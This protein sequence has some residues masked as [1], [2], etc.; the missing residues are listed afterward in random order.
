MT[1]TQLEYLIAVAD[2]GSFSKAAEK[3][4][5]TQ[6]A[7]SMQ[8]HKLEE[9]L[10]VIIF[11]RSKKPIKVTPIG[12][13]IIDQARQNLNGME[14]IKEIIREQTDEINGHLRIGIIPTLAPYL[15]PL[16]VTS[17]LNKY[18]LVSLSI[19][20]FISEQ[21]VDKLKQ[22]R[23]DV[24]ILVTPLNDATV[25]EIH[26]F[27]E[28]FVA[29]IST[30]HPLIH[31]EIIDL[32]DLDIDDMLLLNEGHCFREQVIN[33]CPETQRRNWSTRLRFESGSLE[34]LKRIVERGYGYTLL[35]ELAVLNVARENKKFR[36]ELRE[37][38]PV[39]EVSL[40]VH[41]SI[42]KRNLI[43]V[44]KENILDNIPSSLK[45]DNRGTI[46]QWV[47]GNA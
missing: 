24:G 47:S 1:L 20:E 31:K 2:Y 15:L 22:N 43:N 29:Y 4:F 34:T 6:P 5:V 10:A 38:K 7:L 8:I 28:T 40:V 46:V 23:L 32:N 17:F 25:T 18:P 26:L 33:I 42:L 21:I 45:A 44:L 39:R 35:P 36:K 16:F 41:R 27:Y 11:D 19:E 3:C 9:E 37:P 13:E 14:R 12:E 30:K